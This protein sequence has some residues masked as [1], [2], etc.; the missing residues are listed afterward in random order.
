VVQGNRTDTERL[1]LRPLESAD[2]D[3]AV[4]LGGDHQTW[5]VVSAC[6]N[7]E[8]VGWP[9]GVGEGRRPAPAGKTPRREED[10]EM[11]NA[12]PILIGLDTPTV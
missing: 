2:D 12:A 7:G 4:V 1:L 10:V 6:L 5:G 9:S 3:G 8:S 11:A